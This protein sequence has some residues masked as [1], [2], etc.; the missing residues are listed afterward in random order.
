M[1]GAGKST[2]RKTHSN[3]Q[4]VKLLRC[5]AVDS[6]SDCDSAA[7]GIK[8]I[9]LQP[10]S[11]VFVYK[12]YIEMR[13]YWMHLSHLHVLMDSSFLAQEICSLDMGPATSGASCWQRPSLHSLFQCCRPWGS[14]CWKSPNVWLQPRKCWCHKS[15]LWEKQLCSDL[16]C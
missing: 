14:S 13:F 10:L 8:F 16:Q 2:C 5:R 1:A 9:P 12:V 11:F 4:E 3:P 6:T 15:L 7:K